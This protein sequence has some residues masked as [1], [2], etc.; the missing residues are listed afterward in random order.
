MWRPGSEFFDGRYINE[1]SRDPILSEQVNL[2]MTLCV[3]PYLRQ[4]KPLWLN[5]IHPITIFPT[6]FLDPKTIES[7]H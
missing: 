4:E 1:D 2:W 3:H 7:L 5:L 6:S